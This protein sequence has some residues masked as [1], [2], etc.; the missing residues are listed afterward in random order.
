MGQFDLETD[1]ALLQ[2]NFEE[3]STT[4]GGEFAEIISDLLALIGTGGLW[5]VAGGA[6]NLLLKVRKLAGASYASN[7]IFAITI[8]RNDLK[9]LYEKHAELRER[10]ESLR[11][12]PKFAEAISALALRAMQ[13]SVKG[14]LNRL[15]RIVVNGVKDGDLEP[16]SLDDMMRAAVELTEHDI[17]VLRSIYEMQ[18]YFFTPAEMEKPYNFR[19]DA[20]RSRWK[21]WWEQE[22]TAYLVDGGAAFRSS[23]VRLQ[24]TELIAAIGLVH[25]LTGPS[26]NDFELLFDGKKFY[27]R[28]QEIGSNGGLK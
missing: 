6:S 21:T 20:I 7:L 25:V 11:T 28:L 15:A 10:I 22:G 27:E 3:L 1:A 8:V 26:V 9:D 24:S 14:R 12:D 5:A 16:E 13:T 2:L 4:P 19:I 17:L 23:T 18:V